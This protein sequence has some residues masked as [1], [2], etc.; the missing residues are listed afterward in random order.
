[1]SN[2][3]VTHAADPRAARLADRHYSRQKPGTSQFSPP[4]RKLVLLNEEATALWVTSW[5][6]PEFVRRAYADGWCCSLF[7]NESSVLSSVLI[8]EAVAVTRWKYG[9]PP[10]S[11]MVTMIDAAKVRHKRDPGRC[12]LRAGFRRV[13]MTQGGLIIL[14]LLPEDMPE[15]AMPNGATFPLFEEVSA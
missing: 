15:P 2:W 1:M 4:G 9:N 8:R 11:G 7:R 6:F 12:Y 5:P 13:G 10:D 14:Q 3:Y